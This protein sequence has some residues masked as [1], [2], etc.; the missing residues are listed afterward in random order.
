MT[1]ANGQSVT[2][3]LSIVVST[4]VTLWPGTTVPG[5]VSAGDTNSV[6][7]GV[8]FRST[9]NG[10]ITGIRFYK[11]STNTGTH[12][13]NLW[14]S[15]GTKLATAT[16]TGETASGWQ[17]VLFSS[18]VPIT[19]NTIYVASYHAPNGR[20]SINSNY[21]ATTGVDSPPL[22]ALANGVSGGNGVYAYGAT[23]GFPTQTWNASNYWVDVVFSPGPAPTLSSIAV[24]PASP[25]I[26]TG[27]TQPFTATGTYSN[28]STRESDEPSHMGV[29]EH[30]CGHY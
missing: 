17:Q 12:V 16:F 28:G 2:K 25:T 13:A 21:F 5:V 1:A 23:S 24:I 3:P 4:L 27:S 14:S 6:E 29:L 15:T 8:K 26:S 9:V 30:E 11:A 22:Q 18:P 20:Y 10:S 7:L 19:A